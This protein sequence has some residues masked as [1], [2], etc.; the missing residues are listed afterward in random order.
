MSYLISDF[1]HHVESVLNCNFLGWTHWYIPIK[2]RRSIGCTKESRADANCCV[3]VLGYV[4]PEVIKILSDY[5]MELEVE[6]TINH[7]VGIE[8]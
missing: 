7:L 3:L 4:P 8:T 5:F 6:K 2:E 1:I